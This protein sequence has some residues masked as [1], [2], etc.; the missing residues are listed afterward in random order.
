[1]TVALYPGSF[2][3]IT[4]GHLDVLGRAL[5]VFDR[6]V[7]AVVANP[8]KTPRLD[9]RTRVGVIETAIR[10]AGLDASRAEVVSFDGLTVEAARRHGASVIVRGLRGV[11]DFETELVLAQ[12]NRRLAPEIETV[13]FVTAPEHASISSSLAREIAALGGDVSSLLPAA[14]VAALMTARRR[15]AM[16]PR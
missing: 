12:N 14:A 2:D 9:A 7:V 11:G 6:V 8:S 5:A 1:M 13:C 10:D 4:L 3:P 16:R 15:E